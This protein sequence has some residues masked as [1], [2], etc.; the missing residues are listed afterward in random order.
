MHFPDGGLLYWVM[1]STFKQAAQNWCLSGE[2]DGTGELPLVL[3][4]CHSSR[5][6]R[7]GRDRL[8]LDGDKPS[9]VIKL[10]WN[11]KCQKLCGVTN[12]KV[13]SKNDG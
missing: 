13:R 6:T 12:A 7:S 10:A 2:D 3:H 9:I 11:M 5:A 8:T 4:L 1:R